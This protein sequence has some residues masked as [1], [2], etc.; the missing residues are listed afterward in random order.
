[1]SRYILSP[2]SRDDLDEIIDYI[3]RDSPQAARRVM[4]KIK[5]AIVL[6]AEMPMIG[7][8]REDLTDEPLRFWPVYSCLV[9]YRAERKPLE[10][11][12]ILHGARDVKSILARGF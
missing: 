7:H 6:L 12:R 1:M 10:V 4:K 9:I 3:A 8:L 5:E 2:E 11:V